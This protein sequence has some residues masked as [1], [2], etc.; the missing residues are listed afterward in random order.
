MLA[1][2]IHRDAAHGQ[3]AD[4]VIPA[5][6]DHAGDGHRGQNFDHRV[7]DRVRHDRVFERV[8]V[9]G[10]HFGK[11]VEGALLAVEQLQHHHAADVLLQVG[12]DAG[13]GDANA[14]VG[15]AHLVAEDLGGVGDQRQHGQRDQRQLPVHA[16]HDGGNAGQHEHVFEDRDH[17]GGEHFVQRVHVGG[18]ARDQAADRI[19]VVEADVH[20]LQVAEDLLA[21]I[22]HHHLAG[23]LHEIGLQ[24]FEQETER[25]QAH[26][27][28]RD[29]RD[30]NVGIRRS[31]KDRTACVLGTGTR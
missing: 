7:I 1:G 20:A 17:A 23:P 25:D 29:L 8:H 9:D 10:V 11:L 12:V 28:G 21:Q 27:H 6:P 19:L 13:N 5:K 16:Q 14:A 26:V 4:D 3:L 18:D 2:E 24:I 22:E 30:P 31:E 15:I